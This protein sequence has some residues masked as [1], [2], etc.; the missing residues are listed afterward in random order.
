MNGHNL[1]PEVRPGSARSLRKRLKATWE[2]QGKPVPP[3]L[4]RW[5]R[6]RLVAAWYE[7]LR[8]AGFQVGV[9]A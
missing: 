1:P 2:N 3:D 4:C 6:P 7:V 5:P 9:R 8:R